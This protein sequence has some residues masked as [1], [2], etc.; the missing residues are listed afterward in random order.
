MELPAYLGQ[1]FP[2]LKAHWPQLKSLF[3]PQ[4][5]PAGTTLLSEGQVATEIYIVTSGALRL[6]HNS[7]RQEITLQFFFENQLVSSFES[8]YLDQPSRFSIESFEPTTILALS[9]SAFTQLQQ[10]Y[11]T[12]EPAITR[13]ICERFISYRNVFLDQ[14]ALSPVERYQKLQ[15]DEPDILERVPLQLVASY[16]GI[17]P[18]SLSRIRRRLKPEV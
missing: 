3:V 9:K 14:L 4:Q 6:W 1:Q 12:I 13:F 7:E 15:A 11:P 2:E 5:V 18:V 16:L 10:Q 17:T 8:F